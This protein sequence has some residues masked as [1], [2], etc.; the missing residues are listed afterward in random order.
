M[1]GQGVNIEVAVPYGDAAES[2][3]VEIGLRSADLVVMCTHGRSGLGRWIY[4]SVAEQVLH[5]SPVPV[6]LVHPAGEITTL[7]PER[8]TRR[9]LSRWTV[10]PLRKPRCPTLRTW[11]VRSAEG[12]C[13]S[14]P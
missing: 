8:D 12:S 3:L 14:V 13:W 9:C 7:A 5:R 4:G 11:L 2:I 10:L 1:S 6:V